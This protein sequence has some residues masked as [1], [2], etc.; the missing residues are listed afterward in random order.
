MFT[1]SLTVL[2]SCPSGVEGVTNAVRI[3]APTESL[4]N[5]VVEMFVFPA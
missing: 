5:V 2:K 4:I 3:S 1:R